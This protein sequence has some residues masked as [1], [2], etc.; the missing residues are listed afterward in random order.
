[1]SRNSRFEHL[2]YALAGS[3]RRTTASL[4]M[5]AL[6]SASLG[7]AGVGLTPVA[8]HA[9]PLSWPSAAQ[10]ALHSDDP[11]PEPPGQ[12]HDDFNPQPDPPGRQRSPDFNPQPDPPGRHMG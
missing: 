2:R 6:A 7:L 12:P 1:M 4:A 5:T 9:S 8:V 11:Q 10:N 3:A